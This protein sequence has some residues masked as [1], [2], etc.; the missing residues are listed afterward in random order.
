MKAQSKVAVLTAVFAVVALAAT[1]VTRSS[2]AGLEKSFDRRVERDVLEGDP[3]L[4]LGMTRG[5]YVEGFGAVYSAEVSLAA[6]PGISPFYQERTKADWQRVRQKQMQRLPLLR[7]AMKQAI[8]ESSSWLEAMP[9]SENVVLA[10]TL[11]HHPSEDI[12]GLP[13][14]IVMLAQKLNLMEVQSGKRDR[15]ALNSVIK[16]Q[17]F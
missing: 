15:A 14:Q 3:F 17:E 2:L 13:A 9:A 16:V 6:P 10:V 11:A 5:V 1:R 7:E 4:L 8:L 12:S